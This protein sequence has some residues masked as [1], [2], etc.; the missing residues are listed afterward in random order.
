M[1]AS[2]MSQKFKGFCPASEEQ[3]KQNSAPKQGAKPRAN[4][5]GGRGSLGFT[6]TREQLDAAELFVK[7]GSLRI[8]AYAG[9]GK[10]STL[11][12]LAQ[13]THRQ[14]QYIAFNRSIVTDAKGKFAP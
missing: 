13:S 2:W 4:G 10:T 6:P 3:Q 5:T 9:T 7:G 12:L 11:S 8:N 1:A 14:G